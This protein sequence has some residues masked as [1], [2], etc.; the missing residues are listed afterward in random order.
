[1]MTIVNYKILVN[2]CREIKFFKYSGKTYYSKNS[3]P[4]NKTND[5]ARD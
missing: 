5:I 3:I 1:M 4:Y 2:R